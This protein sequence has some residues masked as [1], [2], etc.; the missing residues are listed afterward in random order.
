[1]SA[2]LGRTPATAPAGGPAPLDSSR[3]ARSVAAV[4]VES[5][6][7][8]LLA[9]AALAAFATAQWGTLVEDPPA[10]R[11]LLVVL[12]ATGGA[13]V[14]GLL[15]RAPLPRTAV[16]VLAA[17]MGVAMLAL[18]LM[19]AGLPGR[20]LLPAHWPEFIDGLDRGLAGVE[21]VEWPYSGPEAWIRL[22]VVLG[23]PALLTIAALLAF[24][25]AQRGRAVLW[26]GG[27]IALLLLY[28]AA[29]AEHDPGAPALRGLVLLILVGAWLW[30]PRMPWREAGV[31]AAVV[32]S[33]GLLS[34]PVAAALDADRP[35]WDYRAWDWF[36]GGKVIT[37]DWNHS[38]GPLDWSRAGATVLNVKSDRPHYWKAE[39]LDGFD[40][41]RW[42]R[43]PDF[44]ETQYGSQVAFT[45]SEI[46]GRWNYNEYNLNWDERIRFTVRSL[47]TQFVVGAGVVLD[48][49]G[50]PARPAGDGT[51]RLLG[52]NR[53]E[54]GDT[55]SVRAY[56]PNPTKAQMRGVPDGYADD[57]VRYTAIQLPLPGESATRTLRGETLADREAAA[58]RRETVFVPL[59][60]DP[61]S[62]DGPHA[63]AQLRD[64]PYGRMYEQA[65]ALTQVEPT[66]YDAVKRVETW[67]QENFTYAERV[68]T[69]RYPL[70]GFLEKDKRG[71]CQQFSGAM[72]LMLRMAG[73]PARV[74]AGFSPGSYNKDTR[75][76]RV[77]DLDAHS[78]VEVWFTGIGW[79]P[80]DP[81]PARAPAQSQSSA[82]AA[83]AAAPRG[84]A[85][86]IR[87]ATA[88][89][90]AGENA[91]NAGG[92]KEGGWV[93]PGLVLLLLVVPLAGA[94]LLVGRRVT[95]LRSL[96][97]DAVA[98]AQ[99][100]ELRRALMRLGW[101]L[102]PSTT[103]LGLERRLGR[104]AGPAS[105]AY[106]GTLRAHRYDPRAPTAPSL[107]ERRAVRRE[108]TRGSL[109]DRLRGL[110]VIP[111]G[112][113][114]S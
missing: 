17:L 65:I 3:P 2:L 64:S 26:I 104:F 101:D 6:A 25:P 8:R 88:S 53:L 29:V 85:G 100:S 110:V 38:Y 36:G 80:F 12:V 24:W 14:L 41:L 109:F 106:A 68:P 19:A 22:T 58:L 113:P 78:W 87:A 34:L 23:A 94:A 102:P 42:F 47:S 48:V 56:A 77:R 44:D 76:Y 67:L 1:M 5:L 57:L 95:R 45:R 52:G 16:H 28:G 73:I 103:L 91:G 50:A 39:T 61:E 21:G 59:Q 90:R 69:Y 15:G 27:L 112:A 92:G 75:E 83:S 82:L 43:K 49:D 108:L 66:P 79:V 18:G 97:P 86:Q 54:E 30:L 13:A 35:W 107:R 9:F 32:A 4:A 99:L 96:P 81:T 89:E 71:Y 93:L 37:F 62:G 74:A 114:R 10:G 84:G 63:D 70:M 46:Q 55:Y 20:L 51:A 60:G 40:G 98:E 72:A 7:M 11:E 33:V 31:A 105:Q 111:P